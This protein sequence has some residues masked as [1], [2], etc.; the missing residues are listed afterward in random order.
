MFKSHLNTALSHSQHQVQ[1]G[2]VVKEEISL[3]EYHDIKTLQH[4]IGEIVYMDA[5]MHA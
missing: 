5:G 1:Y 2:S 3:G 4:A